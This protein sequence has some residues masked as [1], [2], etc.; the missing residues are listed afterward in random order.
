M[1]IKKDWNKLAVAIITGIFG[2]LFFIAIFAETEFMIGKISGLK[3]LESSFSSFAIFWLIPTVFFFGMC[4]F[5]VLKLLKKD[6]A[7]YVILAV[8][9]LNV[10]LYI[11]V[12]IDD[13]FPGFGVFE[14]YMSW[15]PI[16][17]L[18]VLPLIKGLKKV[19]CCDCKEKP[20]AAA[21]K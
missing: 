18:A 4:A 7:K 8:G 1:N 6:F 10:L 12:L 19:L 20:A 15:M 5:S 21:K 11:I 17:V 13:G 9:A 2:L 3:A 14:L 16:V